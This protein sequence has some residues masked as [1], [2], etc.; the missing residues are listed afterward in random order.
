MNKL[1]IFKLCFAI[2]ISVT[3]LLSYK[4]GSVIA[5][6]GSSSGSGSD[7]I[8]NII[9]DKI[10]EGAL[11]DI[12]ENILKNTEEEA[13]GIFK[14]FNPSA[15]AKDIAGTGGTDKLKDLPKNIFIYTLSQIQKNFGMLA[16]LIALA[17]LWGV[18]D[19][20]RPESGDKG[21]GEI[22]HVAGYVVIVA[23]LA[24]NLKDVII[25]AKDTIGTTI[26][27]MHTTIPLLGA[28]AIASGGVVSG[29]VIKPALIASAEA[30]GFLI[31]NIFIPLLTMSMALSIAENLSGEVGPGRI[32]AIL[33]SLTA[34]SLGLYMTIF[35]GISS[36]Q[37]ISGG[38]A[39][40]IAGKTAKFAIGAFIPVVGK[41]LADATDT[42]IGCA[43]VLKNAGTVVALIG[44]LVVCIAP[45]IRLGAII[46]IYRIAAALMSI[47]AD[48]RV[49]SCIDSMASCIS[50]MTGLAV[51][52]ALMAV[53]CMT[54]LAG[55]GVIAAMVR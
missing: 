10:K 1:H 43:L 23:V 45:L 8:G 29:G 21:T 51:C 16:K 39:D 6:D 17:I 20:L 4:I 13:K 40:G 30:G 42:I 28:A 32:A 3:V 47:I 48:K 46:I 50:W 24:T 25:L 19:C 49:S 31:M 34:W 26:S 2:F 38:L 33:R 27:Y 37:A 36:L 44:V 18:L 54:A 7:N 14:N 55:A 41:Y 9:D 12:S 52:A 53:I 5:S 11:K 35:V 15:I 22:F